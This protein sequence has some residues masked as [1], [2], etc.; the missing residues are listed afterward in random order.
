MAKMDPATIRMLA[1]L[2]RYAENVTN[3]PGVRKYRRVKLSN[4]TYH[5]TVGGSKVGKELLSKAGW[6]ICNQLTLFVIR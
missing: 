3:N 5:S 4:S 6:R 2:H 1:L